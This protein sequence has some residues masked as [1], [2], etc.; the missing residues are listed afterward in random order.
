MGDPETQVVLP[1]IKNDFLE[2]MIC[3]A[4]QS[5]GKINLQID[6]KSAS[7]VVMVSGG[8]P[9]EY[10]KGLEISGIPNNSPSSIIFQAGTKVLNGKT[11]TN[12]GRV[13]S[14]TS[15]SKGFK[16]ALK[17]S[18]ETVEKIDYKKKYYRKDLGFDL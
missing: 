13:L 16:K 14:V 8:Y 18:Y 6:P 2:M 9:E 7:T 3:T 11:V 1:R 10:E 5:L 17:K 4:E 15:I 12:G